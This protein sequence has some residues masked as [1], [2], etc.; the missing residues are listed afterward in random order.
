MKKKREKVDQL[1]YSRVIKLFNSLEIDILP[2]GSC[3]VPEAAFDYLDFALISIHSSFNLAK[4]KMTRRILEA[5]SW[6]PKVKI[7]AHP[8]AR[9]IN[10]R[11]K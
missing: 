1:N 10:E 4:E 2:D 5:F 6:N 9:K 7:L 8:T 3:P 11:E